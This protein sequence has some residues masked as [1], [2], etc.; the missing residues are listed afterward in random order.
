[1]VWMAVFHLCFDLNQFGLWAP[2]QSFRADPFWSWQR[3]VIVSL[4]LACAGLGQAVAA[5]RGQ[6]A[7]SFW[8]RW[9]QVAACAVLVSLS[10]WWMFP[11]SWIHFGVLHGMAVMLVLLRWLGPVVGTPSRWPWGV[12]TGLLALLLPHWAR[13]PVFNASVWHWTGLVTRLPVTEDYVPVLPW[14]GVMIW[15]FCA[16]AVML[17]WRSDWLSAPVCVLARP[18]ARLGRWPLSFYMLHQPV[19]LAL[20]SIWV[21]VSGHGRWPV[22]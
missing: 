19:L 10:S 17:R 8:R 13:D 22:S 9:T 11:R 4:F 21:L 1:M 7:A 3:V 6:T 15:S 16:G 20:V 14:F 2:P 12:G 5:E 18:L